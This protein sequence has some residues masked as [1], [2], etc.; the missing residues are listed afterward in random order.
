MKYGNDYLKYAHEKHD[1]ALVIS[2]KIYN[3]S[4]KRFSSLNSIL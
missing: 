1:V 2:D 3:F 4:E